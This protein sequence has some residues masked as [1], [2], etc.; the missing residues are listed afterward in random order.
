M[1]TMTLKQFWKIIAWLL[2]G[3]C[4]FIHPTVAK[5]KLELEGYAASGMIY[6]HE[7]VY[8]MSYYKGKLEVEQKID[9]D[10]EAVLDFRASSETKE[11]ELKEVFLKIDYSPWIHV[12]IGHVKKPFTVEETNSKED[13]PMIESSLMNRTMEPF[14]FVVRGDGMTV[15]RKYKGE[16]APIGYQ[17]GLYYSESRHLY[18]AAR[19]ERF[20]I[21]PLDRVGFGGICRRFTGR[22]EEPVYA[23]SLDAMRAFGKLNAEIETVYGQ[24]P[25]ENCYRKMEG[26]TDEAAFIGGRLLLTYNYPVNRRLFTALEP[27]AL[28]G[29]VAPDT[30]RMEVHKLQCLLGLNIYLHDKVRIRLNGDLLLSNNRLDTSVYAR[31]GTNFMA[32]VQTRW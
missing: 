9:D 27:V 26:R 1:N 32:E 5:N 28:L 20:E 19:V 18:G 3:C 6:W 17:A 16:G 15:Y 23:L 22:G 12:K 4:F 14:G 13:L 29:F 31:T 2:S 11:V 24:D 25:V 21:G 10:L 8:G 30:D 7:T